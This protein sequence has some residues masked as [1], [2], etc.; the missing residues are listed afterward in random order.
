[1]AILDDNKPRIILP[2]WRNVNSDSS[3]LIL[4]SEIKDVGSSNISTDI[5][6]QSKIEFGEN[7]TF[8]NALEVVNSGLL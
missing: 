4:Q 7:K 3:K 5:F 8:S 6:L 2:R 1:M